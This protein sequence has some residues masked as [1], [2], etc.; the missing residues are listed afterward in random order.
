MKCCE[1]ESKF[2]ENLET[3]LSDIQLQ[4][5]Q[6]LVLQ[7][8]KAVRDEFLQTGDRLIETNEQLK[9]QR[10]DLVDLQKELQELSKTDLGIFTE[11]GMELR[12]EIDAKKILSI[13]QKSRLSN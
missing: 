7:T 11:R 3:S 1:K 9:S 10:Q 5:Q 12:K 2:L 13:L 4:N 8:E 6:L